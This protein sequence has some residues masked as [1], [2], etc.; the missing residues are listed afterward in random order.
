[1]QLQILIAVHKCHN[2]V[3]VGDCLAADGAGRFHAEL[4]SR[5]SGQTPSGPRLANLD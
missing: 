3:V 5:A 4:D 1:M 2:E